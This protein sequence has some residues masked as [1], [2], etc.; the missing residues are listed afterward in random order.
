MRRRP[1]ILLLL[2][3]LVA[4]ASVFAAPA[5]QLSDRFPAATLSEGAQEIDLG[6]GAMALMGPW[7][8][9]SGND[10]QWAQP[11]FDDSG[12]EGYTIRG[13]GW[14]TEVFRFGEGG[15]PGWAGHGHRGEWGRWLVPHSR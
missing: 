11:G 2:L 13:Q 4:P 8:F 12:W 14:P 6:H 10:P 3:A 9:R 5:A 1:F 7:K 15:D